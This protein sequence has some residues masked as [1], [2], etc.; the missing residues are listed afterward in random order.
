VE[1]EYYFRRVLGCVC[2][3]REE[4]HLVEPD[5]GGLYRGR[6][7]VR[8]TK[9]RAR[10]EKRTVMPNEKPPDGVFCTPLAHASGLLQNWFPERR[11]ER[12]GESGGSTTAP[13]KSVVCTFLNS[14]V[15]WP[16]W[17]ESIMMLAGLISTGCQRSKVDTATH[18]QLTGV[19]NAFVVK[20]G[21]ARQSIPQDILQYILR[22]LV[23]EKR[24]IKTDHVT[25]G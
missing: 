25:W 15:P 6:E 14:M 4:D 23:A 24:I 18:G 8:L 19:I 12:P 2:L 21:Q 1:L 9:V 5:I 10:V 11:F 13:C 22:T 17:N 7:L 20:I 3:V 16:C